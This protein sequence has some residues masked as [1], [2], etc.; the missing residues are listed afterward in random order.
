MLVIA[1]ELPQQAAVPATQKHIQYAA[2]PAQHLTDASRLFGCRGFLGDT[3]DL[4]FVTDQRSRKVWQGNMGW[5]GGW[6]GG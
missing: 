2:A 3:D 6:V 1:C 4:T 5:V